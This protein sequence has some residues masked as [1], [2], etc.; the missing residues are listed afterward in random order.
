MNYIDNDYINGAHTKILQRMLE[1]NDEQT[2]GYGFDR[3]L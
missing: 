3:F 1:T 2:P